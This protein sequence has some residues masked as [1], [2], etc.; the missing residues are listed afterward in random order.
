MEGVI[1][2]RNI[3]SKML[4]NCYREDLPIDGYLKSENSIISCENQVLSAQVYRSLI[5][6][7][8]G[9]EKSVYIFSI[10]YYQRYWYT[11]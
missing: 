5:P 11:S 6:D 10:I 1:T 8:R 2:R 3:K 4:L 9:W 7:L